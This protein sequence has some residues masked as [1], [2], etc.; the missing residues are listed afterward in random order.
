MWAVRVKIELIFRI[1]LIISSIIGTVYTYSVENRP[2]YISS[3]IAVLGTTALLLQY[4][5]TIKNRKQH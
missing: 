2:T 5:Y 3:I 1:F 4:I